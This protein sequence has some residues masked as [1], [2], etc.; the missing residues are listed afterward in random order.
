MERP[1]WSF[2]DPSGLGGSHQDTLEQTRI[3]RGQTGTK[4]IDWIKGTWGLATVTDFP[5]RFF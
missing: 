1:H 4:V 2:E 5:H 3:I